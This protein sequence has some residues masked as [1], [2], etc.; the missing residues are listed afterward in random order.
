MS[1]PGQEMFEETEAAAKPRRASHPER[2]FLLSPVSVARQLPGQP[3]VTKELHRVWCANG[4]IP[5]AE[6]IGRTILVAS[7]TDAFGILGM[8]H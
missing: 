3:I 4:A 8:E 5:A 7:P 2:T 1:F 6:T